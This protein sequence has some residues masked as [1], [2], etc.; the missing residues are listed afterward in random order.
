MSKVNSE[1]IFIYCY[2]GTYFTPSSSASVADL[3]GKNVCW[4]ETYA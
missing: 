4:E 2:L 3:E 1:D